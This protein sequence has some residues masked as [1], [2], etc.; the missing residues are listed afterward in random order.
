MLTPYGT[1]YATLRRLAL[2][3]TPP[4]S[5]DCRTAERDARQAHA[6]GERLA[7]QRLL[8][9]RALWSALRAQP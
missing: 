6:R 9:A 4:T 3:G 5:L 8:I 7:M 1:P 2:H